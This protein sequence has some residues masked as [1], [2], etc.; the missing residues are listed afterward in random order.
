MLRGQGHWISPEG[1]TGRQL[2]VTLNPQN[3]VLS[4]QS[5]LSSTLVNEAKVGFNEALSR[6]NGVAPVIPGVD[7][8]TI[9]GS[10]SGNVANTGHVGQGS[11][12][13]VPTPGGLVR[14][15]SASN[16]QSQAYTH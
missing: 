3:A 9:A 14:S 13:C 16:D 12:T 6:I 10:V 7:L 15:H 8:S 5:N 11:D 1:V 2:L 4:L